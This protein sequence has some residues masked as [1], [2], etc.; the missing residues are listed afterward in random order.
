MNFPARSEKTPPTY[1]QCRRRSAPQ[2]LGD[3]SQTCIVRVRACCRGG[4]WPGPTAGWGLA[5]G[6][7]RSESA[8]WLLQWLSFAA[9][10]QSCFQ[11]A[12]P[13][14]SLA[15]TPRQEAGPQPPGA[16]P[17]AGHYPTAG[18]PGVGQKCFFNNSSQ[19]QSFSVFTPNL[20]P[21]SERIGFKNQKAARQASFTN[22][23]FSRL[24]S[25]TS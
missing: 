1:C 5:R 9:V 25:S 16:G 6:F 18:P 15:C 7:A 4:H 14:P 22:S 8:L 13:R 12:S 11:V 2:L 19:H 21:F 3:F 17:Q 20:A 24:V 10:Q 23:H